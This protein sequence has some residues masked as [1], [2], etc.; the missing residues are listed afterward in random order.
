M[1][2]SELFHVIVPWCKKENWFA[3]YFLKLNTLK[4]P[5][6]NGTLQKRN[7]RNRI[8]IGY[9]QLF[10]LLSLLMFYYLRPKHRV[11]S[12]TQVPQ[13]TSSISTCPLTSIYHPLENKV[14]WIWEGSQRVLW[15]CSSMASS[16]E[17]SITV[18]IYATVK[19]P[20][21]TTWSIKHLLKSHMVYSLAYGMVYTILPKRQSIWWPPPVPLP[22]PRNRKPTASAPFQLL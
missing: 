20:H 18:A 14:Q 1:S 8:V 9:R 21:L 4:P 10:I 5:W 22:Q 13:T 3:Y 11:N 12:T 17:F 19:V 6:K 15:L 2:L 16:E 7:I